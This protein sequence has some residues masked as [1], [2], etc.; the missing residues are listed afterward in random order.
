MGEGSQLSTS[1][2]ERERRSKGF[3]WKPIQRLSWFPCTVKT[4]LPWEAHRGIPDNLASNEATRYSA[5]LPYSNH[6]FSPQVFREHRTGCLTMGATS[7]HGPTAWHKSNKSDVS[8]CPCS[9]SS[10]PEDF[11]RTQ[12][13]DKNSVR[14]EKSCI[15]LSARSL[16]HLQEPWEPECSNPQSGYQFSSVISEERRVQFFFFFPRAEDPIQGLALNRSTTELNSYKDKH[17]I[18]AGLQN[19]KSRQTCCWRRSW[20]FYIWRQQKET[21]CHTGC[22]LSIYNLKAHLHSDTFPPT[23]PH[24]LQQG[25]T[26]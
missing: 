20:E 3:Q 12:L 8:F 7:V 18:G 5:Y 15:V 23:K 19:C 13:W 16:P 24:L 14:L 4:H 26:S 21:V 25:H 10:L 6:A 1:Q 11:N 9:T 17:L 2:Q 22:S